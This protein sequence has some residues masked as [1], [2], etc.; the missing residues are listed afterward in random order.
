MNI[1]NEGGAAVDAV[2][3]AIRVLEDKEITNA[4]FGSNLSMD[5][6][7]ECDATIID[8][9]GRSG[10]VGA[11]SRKSASCLSHR[12]SSSLTVAR[13]PAP[14]PPCSPYPGLFHKTSLTE[15]RTAQSSSWSWGHR[16][17]SISSSSRRSSRPPHI[18]RRT[19]SLEQM[20]SRP[21]D[22][23]E[24]SAGNYPRA[25]KLWILIASCS[26]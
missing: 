14:N 15:A 24:Q 21:K 16:L 13:G 17:C 4:G 22:C 5:G 1:L 19:R 11:V 12:S 10:A 3:V 9:Y 18:Q 2:E 8:H 7:V 6:A 26:G 23:R 25:G 20:G